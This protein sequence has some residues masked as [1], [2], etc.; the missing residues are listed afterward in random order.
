MLQGGHLMK[1]LL[2]TYSIEEILIF[3]VVLAIAIKGVITFFDWAK[4]RLKRMFDKENIE[5]P[6]PIQ[7][8]EIKK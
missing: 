1:E 7:V 8:V 5:I 6:Y 2:T 3:L 4:D